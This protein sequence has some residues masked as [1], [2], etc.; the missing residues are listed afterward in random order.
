MNLSSV[1]RR[2]KGWNVEFK[3]LTGVVRLRFI[4]KL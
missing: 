4:A 2:R 3:G 1:G